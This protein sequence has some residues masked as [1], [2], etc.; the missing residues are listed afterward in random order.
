[1][2]SEQAAYQIYS[3][4]GQNGSL[5]LKSTQGTK[6]RRF[7]PQYG[8]I[9]MEVEDWIDA[10]N[11]PEWQRDNKQIYGPEDP[12]YVLEAIYKFSVNK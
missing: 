12:P 6:S 8:C 7:V 10:I 11:Q 3:C 4:G 5:A 1:V 2:F 9:V